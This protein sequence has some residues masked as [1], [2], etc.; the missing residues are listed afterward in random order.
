MSN[1]YR[2]SNLTVLNTK[3]IGGNFIKYLFKKGGKNNGQL[4]LDDLDESV[5][6]KKLE[7]LTKELNEYK[8]KCAKLYVYYYIIHCLSLF[9][10]YLSIYI[11]L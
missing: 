6:K 3:T 7:S 1:E 9:L 5:L 10:H 8:D 4:V 2:Q 11:V